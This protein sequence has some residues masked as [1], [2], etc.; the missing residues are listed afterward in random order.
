MCNLLKKSINE[1]TLE[2]RHGW[3]KEII[4][5]KRIQNGNRIRP[6][7]M[8]GPSQTQ[9]Y[10]Q[11]HGSACSSGGGRGRWGTGGGGSSSSRQRSSGLLPWQ[12]L[13]TLFSSIP[14]HF[15]TRS[16]L[17]SQAAG[18]GS[19]SQFLIGCWRIAVVEITD[20]KIWPKPLGQ[21]P[22]RFSAIRG[23]G[24]EGRPGPTWVTGLSSG[25]FLLDKGQRKLTGNL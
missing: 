4:Q 12:A 19:H 7:P 6:S 13:L 22:E 2:V 11:P 10:T 18:C 16:W 8:S 15:T 21:L 17:C 25:W 14:P 9:P 20:T 1:V 23:V 5:K 3:G 24:T